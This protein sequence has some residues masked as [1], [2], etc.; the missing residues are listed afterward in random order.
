MQS[1]SRT[2][3]ALLLL[4]GCA[5]A[6]QSSSSN[7]A[8]LA[9]S[10]VAVIDVRDGRIL[11]GQ[12]VLIKGNRI[13]AIADA[14]RVRI[15]M[16][17]R[18]IDGTGKYLIPGLLDMHVHLTL[19]GR[20]TQI[21]LPLFVAHGITGV[22]VMG[23]DC[24]RPAPGQDACLETHRDWQKRIEAGELEGPRLLALASWPVNGA[25][26]VT[27]SMPAFF[28]ATTAED[29]RQLARYF[30]QRG[31][32]LIK[33]YNGVSRAG[34]LGLS[35]EARKLNLPFAGH[36]PTSL[37]AIELSDAGQKSI[38]HS[39]IFLFNCFPGADSMRKGLLRLPQTA[40]RRRMVDEY[41]A[42]TCAEVFSTFA[43]N[44]T[45]ITPTHLTRR[46]DALAHDSAFRQDPR[47]KL[48]PPL[49]RLRW[50][51][52]A[53]QMVASDSSAA[54]RRGFMDFY[55]KGLELT[56]AAYRAGVPVML[57]TDAGDSYVFPGASV[58]DELEELVKAGLSPAEALKAATL[59][60]I[61]YLGRTADLGTLEAGKLAD[62]VLLD[63]NPLENITN[64]RRI[65][66]VLING[67]YYDRARLDQMMAE[68][69]ANANRQQ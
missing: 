17:A 27:D 44:R 58:H 43:R 38:E 15:A 20:P 69:E 16:P 63:Q 18:V 45:Y 46:M 54:G 2:V 28:K 12:T 7:A 3:L 5:A 53:N 50:L 25:Q 56:N 33:I 51:V 67:R 55:R 34:Y 36:E 23:A 48:I 61:E 31:V 9:I 24:R 68:V 21:E 39:R 37:S 57:G 13:A 30:K 19:S 47:M 14:S 49:Q 4:A 65:Q 41:D 42:G 8:D 66:G 22:R 59:A 29:G 60:G 52:D 10:N 62:A 64:T 6:P 40:L 32:D 35:E 26:G 11:P 1:S